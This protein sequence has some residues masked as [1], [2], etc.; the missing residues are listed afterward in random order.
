MP[1]WRRWTLWPSAIRRYPR[2]WWPTTI[3]ASPV[4]CPTCTALTI[5]SVRNMSCTLAIGPIWRN[6]CLLK[7]KQTHTHRYTLKSKHTVYHCIKR[8]SNKIS[9]FYTI[10]VSRVDISY[11]NIIEGCKQR[12]WGSFNE[13]RKEVNI[14]QQ[15]GWQLCWTDCH[16]SFVNGIIGRTSNLSL[17]YW[18]RCLFF[19]A[20]DLVSSTEPQK[21]LFES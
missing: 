11:A 4:A 15:V 1:I 16:F 18:S 3:G 7:S 13:S 21:R 14:F 19:F 8:Y 10:I 5:L 9:I 20:I 12:Y 6:E 2:R 17:F